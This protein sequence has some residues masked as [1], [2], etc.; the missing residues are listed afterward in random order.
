MAPS[1][2]EFAHVRHRRHDD[3]DDHYYSLSFRRATLQV[4]RYY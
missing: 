3:D 2:R 1:C 4:L